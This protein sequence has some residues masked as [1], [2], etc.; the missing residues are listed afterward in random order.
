M[1]LEPEKEL[2]PVHPK[3]TLE[4]DTKLLT[5]EKTKADLIAFTKLRGTKEMA[6]REWSDSHDRE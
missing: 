5:Y 6:L 3:I 4:E 2:E 1:M